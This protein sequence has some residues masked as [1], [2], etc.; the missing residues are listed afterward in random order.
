MNKYLFDIVGKDPSTNQKIYK[1]K[2][3]Q[4]YDETIIYLSHENQDIYNINQIKIM[5]DKLQPIFQQQNVKYFEFL[6]DF[7]LE[8]FERV[9]HSVEHLVS[10]HRFYTE[11]IFGINSDKNSEEMSKNTPPESIKKGGKKIKIK[12]EN[13]N[14]DNIL[15]MPDFQTFNQKIVNQNHDLSEDQKIYISTQYKDNFLTNS[16]LVMTITKPVFV[17]NQFYSI[18]TIDI[19]LSRLF[20]YAGGFD[21]K[22]ENKQKKCSDLD[23]LLSHSGIDYPYVRPSDV[24]YLTF[25]RLEEDGVEKTE[26]ITPILPATTP[27][28]NPNSNFFSEFPPFLENLSISPQK[29]YRKISQVIKKQV[30]YRHYLQPDAT[31][32]TSQN[33]LK[34]IYQNLKDPQKFYQN[35]FESSMKEK[36]YLLNAT[37]GNIFTFNQDGN[38]IADDY[39]L[40]KT[41]LFNSLDSIFPTFQH[42]YYNRDWNHRTFHSE[43]VH[44]ESFVLSQ[45]LHP[46]DR[47]FDMQLKHEYRLIYVGPLPENSSKMSISELKNMPLFCLI[48]KHNL[49]HRVIR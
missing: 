26:E 45:K 46:S 16:P 48:P 12:P 18:V 4:E 27:F 30:I 25:I 20:E 10:F 9:F 15:T 23:Q 7:I 6:F 49:D 13:Y 14:T 36:E 22:I 28:T 41:T 42:H 44:K 33:T 43:I 39:K 35:K 1:S 21:E 31:E 32:F 38:L 40:D 8:P 19:I 47:S 11:E 37:L 2:D 24:G 5:D 29:I 34:T 3:G 17:D